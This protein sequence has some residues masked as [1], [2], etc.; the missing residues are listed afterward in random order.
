MPTAKTLQQVL[1]DPKA[2]PD[3]TKFTLGEVE[4]TLGDLRGLSQVEQK[5]ISDATAELTKE[6][7]ALSAA[8]QTLAQNFSKLVEAGLVTVDPDSGEFRFAEGKPA[9]G[10]TPAGDTKPID[11]DKD[12]YVGPV[13]KQVKALEA[14]VKAFNE[15][16]AKVQKELAGSRTLYENDR[17][18]SVFNGFNDWPEGYNLERAVK[19]AAAQRKT[20]QF[21]RFDI[22][23]IHNELAKPLRYSQTEVDKL[24]E[25]RADKLVQER[26]AALAPRPGVRSRANVKQEFKNLDEAMNAA[27]QDPEVQQSLTNLQILPM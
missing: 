24:V 19:E 14:Q 25:E 2:F 1:A 10:V 22:A 5:R 11:Y 26:N 23:S 13:M 16:V 7:E 8:Q 17:L 27:A 3:D 21:G 6:K 12:T 20:D 9:A 15:G 18:V 4:T